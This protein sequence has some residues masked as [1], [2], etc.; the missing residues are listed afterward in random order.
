MSVLRQH[1]EI[2]KAKGENK[3]V[4]DVFFARTDGKPLLARPDLEQR[5]AEK[6]GACLCVRG[7]PLSLFVVWSLSLFPFVI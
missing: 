1:A 6:R 2:L 7:F 4:A 3:A 5:K